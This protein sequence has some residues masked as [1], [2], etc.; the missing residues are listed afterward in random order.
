MSR[1]TQPLVHSDHLLIALPT[2]HTLV[3]TLHAYTLTLSTHGCIDDLQAMQMTQ[4]I[5]R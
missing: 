5:L 2:Q 3:L 4:H 1:C